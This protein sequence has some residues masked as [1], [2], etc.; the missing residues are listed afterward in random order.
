MSRNFSGMARRVSRNKSRTLEERHL[1]TLRTEE[2]L[3]IF[4]SLFRV[5]PRTGEDIEIGGL[6]VLGEVARDTACLDK[7]DKGIAGRDGIIVAEVGDLRNAVAH[8][9]DDIVAKRRNKLSYLF[10]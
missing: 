6:L 7:L 10:L 1:D 4:S 3:T 8:H 9:L 5:E 2:V